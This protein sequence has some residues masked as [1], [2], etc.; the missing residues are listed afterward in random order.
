MFKDFKS[1]AITLLMVGA[2]YHSTANADIEH[3]GQLSEDEIWDNSDTHLVTGDIYIPSGITLTISSGAM[4]KFAALSDSN[5]LGT[6]ASLSELIADGGTL[7][8]E[9]SSADKV[10]LTSDADTP[11]AGDWRGIRVINGGELSLRH[12]EI[13]YAVTGVDYVQDGEVTRSPVIEDNVFEQLSSN[14]IY[15]ESQGGAQITLSIARNSMSNLGHRGV[16]LNSTNANTLVQG[17]IEDNSITSTGLNGVYFY[18]NSQARHD[19]TLSGNTIQITGS[20]A[21][22]DND[23][24][25]LWL[26]HSYSGSTISDYDINSNEVSA[27]ASYGFYVYHWF[28]NVNLMLLGNSIHDN[29][30]DGIYSYGYYLTANLSL[31]HN[32]VYANAGNGIRLSDR[33]VK[34][35]TDINAT[36]VLNDVYQNTGNGV[37]LYLGRPAHVVHN[38]IHEN[39]GRGVHLDLTQSSYVN[40][41]NLY[42]NDSSDGIALY[43]NGA[44]AVDARYNWWGDTLSAEIATGD[45]PTNLTGIYDVYDDSA[46][47]SVNYSDWLDEV[48]SEPLPTDPVSWVKSPSDG[49]VIKAASYQ[50]DGSAS[51]LSEIDRVEVSTDGGITWE[52]AT[53]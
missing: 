49:L 27:S 19:L 40:F 10:I 1:I 15:L 46:K 43:N 24:A 38:S 37:N 4:I 53:G 41:N 20:A 9:G 47:G 36:L 50:I 22:N 31:A 25:G 16:Y 7:I 23:R 3:A 32:S 48:Q 39:G 14:G 44:A 8:I 2:L 13:R 34:R 5:N 18:A 29:A 28:A 30:N 11:A 17:L 52:L 21:T 6:D 35:V 12:A 51:S 45:N 26:S 42:G 33:N